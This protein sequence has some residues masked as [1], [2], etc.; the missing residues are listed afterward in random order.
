M[1]TKAKAFD[2]VEMKRQG[3]ALVLRQLAGTTRQQ[4]LEYWQEQTELLRQRQAE[5]RDRKSNKVQRP[6]HLGD[7]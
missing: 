3:A 7:H 2:C 1:K 5:L 6:A 4:Q